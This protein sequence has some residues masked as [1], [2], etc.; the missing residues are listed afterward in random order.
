MAAD[1]LNVPCIPEKV[2]DGRQGSCFTLSWL[3]FPCASQSM[4]PLPSVA[5]HLIFLKQ[6]DDPSS[7][8]MCWGVSHMGLPQSSFQRHFLKKIWT[9]CNVEGLCWLWISWMVNNGL[10]ILKV[11]QLPSTCPGLIS[12]PVFFFSVLTFKPQP[13]L[14]PRELSLTL[15]TLDLI[16]CTSVLTEPLSMPQDLLGVVMC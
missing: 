1:L 9:L 4:L 2:K 13:T 8:E 6:C 15:L 16:I 14:T 5:N 12:P 3:Q 10:Q 11:S 7:G